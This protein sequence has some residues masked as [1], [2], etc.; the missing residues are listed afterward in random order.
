VGSHTYDIF[1]TGDNERKRGRGTWI[2]AEGTNTLQLNNDTGSTY[3]GEFLNEDFT[4]ITIR[5]TDG[6][7]ETVLTKQ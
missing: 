2:L 1:V 5:T 4:T 7:W 6:R 3:I